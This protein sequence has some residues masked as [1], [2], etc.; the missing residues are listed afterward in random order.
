[1]TKFNLNVLLLQVTKATI[2]VR[3]DGHVVNRMY[4][5]P[6]QDHPLGVPLVLFKPNRG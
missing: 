2:V 6:N 5:S 3:E 1:M 4:F